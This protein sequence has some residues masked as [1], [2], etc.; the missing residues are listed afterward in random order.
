MKPDEWTHVENLFHAALAVE[1][2]LRPA[3][4]AGAC[5]G[6]DSLRREV[7]SLV[8]AYESEQTFME[9]P[10]LSD[11][12]RVL[13]GIGPESLEGRVFNHYK[14]LRLLG[15]GG[16]G[17]VYLAKDCKL[18]RPVALKF[19]AG[20]SYDDEGAR[21]LLR[22]EARAV[23]KLEHPNICAVHGMEEADGYHF[24]VM[25]F[26]EGE[27]L[28]SLLRDGPLP[29]L[30]SLDLAEQM[31]A[32]LA[33]AHA[34]GVVHRDI[35][36]QNIIISSRGTV[37]ILDFGLAKFITLNQGAEEAND[38][39]RTSQFGL[40]VGTVAYMSPEQT[41]GTELDTRSDIFSLGVVFYEMISGVNPFRRDG[42]RE[43]LKAINQDDPP[44]LTHSAAKVAPRLNAIVR[45]CIEKSRDRRYGTADELLLDIRKLRESARRR[46]RLRPLAVA[47]LAL[48]V[49]FGAV[50]SLTYASYRR[51][52]SLAILHVRGEGAGD[53]Q[54][55]EGLSRSLGHRLSRL[56]RLQVKTP[57]ETSVTEGTDFA[58][59]GREIGVEAV[60]MIR[61]A[62]RDGAPALR[63]T[64]TDTSDGSEVLLGD[65]PMTSADLPALQMDAMRK[66]AGGL[67][68]WLSG[69]D[70][71]LLSRRQTGS[72]EAQELYLRGQHYL[73][74]RDQKNIRT[75]IDFF[76]RALELDPVF[77]EAHAALAESYALLQSPAYGPEPSDQVVAK[78][79]YSA[80]Q[81]LKIDGTLCEAHTALGIIQ[82][83][84]EWNW[85]EAESE[86]RRAIELNPD[87]AP[88][89]FWYSLLLMILSRNDEAI[90]ES[91][92]ASEL[93]PFS[94]L[95]IMNVGRSYYYAGLYDKASEHFR[96]MLEKDRGDTRAAYMLGLVYLHQ[97]ELRKG[98]ETL[99]KLYAE[100]PLF[101][102]APLGYAYAK[103]NRRGEALAVLGKLD[104]LAAAGKTVPAQ[105]KAII[106][107]GLKNYDKAFQLLEEAY[108]ERFGPLASLTTERLFEDLRPDPRFND[109][110]RRLNL[111]P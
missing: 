26:V 19:L 96:A 32:A 18:E 17:Q 41:E 63:L 8:E 106:H 31:A 56:S 109:L 13:K 64:L 62:G 14:V 2:S 51:V 21:E 83:R 35:K 84:H 23:A 98:I 67:G 47:A 69:E 34:G 93:E 55:N 3:Y 108:R 105:E 61:I 78:A 76:L 60:L 7:E 5:T 72:P 77:A 81:A 27:T 87:Y 11:G 70:E 1:A 66:V 75:A 110:A 45:R 22:K 49:I 4:L 20:V 97:G 94:R 54:F 9:E 25:Q 37:K 101:A 30:R 57:K 73:S 44:P 99:E 107:I 88:A 91:A 12:L 48:L 89:H 82:L 95:A 10:A 80:R 42:Q 6:D 46:Q 85:R 38:L 39:E 58:K 29:L 90:A 40:I 100:D 103:T 33:A 43:T 16:M 102:A 79:R 52:H 86:F 92:R 36:P 24:L 104:E 53:D 68:L 59:A 28:T 111:A 65:M 71:K 15:E 74:R 50:G